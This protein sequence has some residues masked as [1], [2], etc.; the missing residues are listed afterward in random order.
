MGAQRA[1]GD[2]GLAGVALV[3]LPG[4]KMIAGREQLKPGVRRLCTDPEL[5]RMTRRS[6]LDEAA[7]DRMW[8]I[9]AH[10]MEMTG[11]QVKRAGDGFRPVSL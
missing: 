10:F 7:E 1:H 9:P 8:L 4:L 6:F 2:P 3:R 11:V 5:A